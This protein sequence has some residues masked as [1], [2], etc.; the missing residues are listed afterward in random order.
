[1]MNY[2]DRVPVQERYNSEESLEDN[3]STTSSTESRQSDFLKKDAEFIPTRTT[4]ILS[5]KPAANPNQFTRINSNPL[6]ISAQKQMLLVEEAKKKKIEVK[7]HDEEPEWQ[8]N[9]DG[10]KQRRRK[11]SEDAMF[12]LSEMK[13]I[14]D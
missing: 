5:S 11:Q 7:K 12:R 2:S 8:S 3:H 1:M 10:W 6:L 14:E 13:K 9:L 4:G